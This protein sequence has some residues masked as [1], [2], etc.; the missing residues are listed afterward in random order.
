MFALHR[1]NA[2]SSARHCLLIVAN[3]P[4][5]HGAQGGTDGDGLY[6]S[7]TFDN[8]EDAAKFGPYYSAMDYES[9]L[10]PKLVV[11][12]E[13]LKSQGAEKIGLIGFC[14]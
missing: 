7:F 6:P 5:R 3:S 1:S 13:H 9:F 11:A 14:W 10:A 12:T 8:A 2:N 4:L